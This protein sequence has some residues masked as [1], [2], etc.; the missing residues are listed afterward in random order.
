M[1]ARDQ[2]ALHQTK[3]I[4]AQIADALKPGRE[5][6]SMESMGEVQPDPMISLFFSARCTLANYCNI[7]DQIWT[8]F[9]LKLDYY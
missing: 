1:A 7:Y 2:I 4:P 6:K 8:W 9:F 5:N 3:M